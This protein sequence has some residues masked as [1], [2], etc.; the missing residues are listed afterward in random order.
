VTHD[1]NLLRHL[2][3]PEKV[4][5]AGLAGGKLS[6]EAAL[7]S[8]QLPTQLGQLFGVQMRELSLD[9][10]RVLLPERPR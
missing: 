10:Q 8:Q 6:F 4:R 7:T 9:G 2:G 5:V 3:D 1:I